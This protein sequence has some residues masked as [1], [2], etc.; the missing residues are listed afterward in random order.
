MLNINSKVKNLDL[1]TIKNMEMV[2]VTALK[3]LHQPLKQIVFDVSFV[4]EKKIRDLNR[5]E[6]NIDRKTDVLSFPTLDIQAGEIIDFDKYKFDIDYNNNTL[7]V[8]EIFIC[9]QVAIRQAKKYGHSY[10]REVCF[11]FLHGI[12]HC[13]G[14]DHIVD[15]DRVI[16]EALQDKI[17]K[18]C[19]ITRE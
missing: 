19:N 10:I 9:N 12:L 2:L 18:E 8:G 17:L 11:L 14:Y 1:N 6:R 5:T 7:L 13:L 16:M 4:G 15:S 3:Y